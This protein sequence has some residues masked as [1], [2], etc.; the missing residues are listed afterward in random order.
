MPGEYN[1]VKYY[2]NYIRK[3]KTWQPKARLIRFV[4]CHC[5]QRLPMASYL[6]P[7]YKAKLGGNMQECGYWCLHCN[8]GG[9]GGRR[10]RTTEIELNEEDDVTYTNV[11]KIR[12]W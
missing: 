10:D 1:G 2:K 8:F 11:S 6:I 9:A 5:V 4:V 12:G 3:L 7:R